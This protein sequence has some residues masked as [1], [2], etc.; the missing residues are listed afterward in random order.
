MR[1]AGP[2]KEEGLWD[3]NISKFIGSVDSRSLG[4]VNGLKY[5]RLAPGKSPSGPTDREETVSS[6][7]TLAL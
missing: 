4:F 1:P 3:E 2:A 7:V 5:R 6:A